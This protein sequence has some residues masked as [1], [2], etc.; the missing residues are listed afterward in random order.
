MS[1][2]REKIL[3]IYEK[4]VASQPEIQRKGAAN[5]YTSMNGNMF[6]FITKEDQIAL[7]LPDELREKMKA[8]PVIQYNSVM[9]GYALAPKAMLTKPAQLAK[10]FAQSVAYAKTLPAKPTTKKKVAKKA[11]KKAPTRRTR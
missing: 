7:R 3:V 5:P 2:S 10:L 1:D 4:M 9:R 8:E 6:S 11:S